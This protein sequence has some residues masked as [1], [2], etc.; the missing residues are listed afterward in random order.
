[1]SDPGSVITRPGFLLPY[2]PLGYMPPPLHIQHACPEGRHYPAPRPLPGSQ[3]VQPGPPLNIGGTGMPSLGIDPT[4]ET[5][6]GSRGY[7]PCA[8]M[9]SYLNS[10]LAWNGS[11][12]LNPLGMQ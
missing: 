1:M 2:R 5:T 6:W 4:D 3:G 11:S 9:I 7:R 10:P 8:G 12:D